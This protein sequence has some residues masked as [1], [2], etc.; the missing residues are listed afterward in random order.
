MRDK[1]EDLWSDLYTITS[2]AIAKLNNHFKPALTCRLN[3]NNSVIR[4]Y[5]EKFFHDNIAVT[6]ELEIR[7]DRGFKKIIVRR[8]DGSKQAIPY[9]LKADLQNASLGLVVVQF[10]FHRPQAAIR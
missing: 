1:I 2:E 8:V 6:P 5:G 4:V 3:D 9:P 10:D 7:F